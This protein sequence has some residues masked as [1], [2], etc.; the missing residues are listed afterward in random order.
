MFRSCATSKRFFQFIR[1]ISPDKHTFTICHIVDVSP[2]L[3]SIRKSGRLVMKQTY[4]PNFVVAFWAMAII[5]LGRALPLGSS[6]LPENAVSVSRNVRRAAVNT[7]LFD[8]APRGVCLAVPVTRHAG[9][10]LPHRFTHHH[11]SGWSVFCCTC[12]RSSLRPGARKLSG[13]LPYGVR[14]FLYCREA[15]AIARSASL[16][17]PSIITKKRLTI[18]HF[19]TCFNGKGSLI[20]IQVGPISV[21][22]GLYH[23]LNLGGGIAFFN[24]IGQQESLFVGDTRN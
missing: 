4:K 17:G 18:K 10:L 20:G 9:E 16:H 21:Y 2:W 3:G 12:R 23:I 6:D 11:R 22:I 7:S 14:T 15:I 19:V 5:H 24:L 8:L 1:N 13:S